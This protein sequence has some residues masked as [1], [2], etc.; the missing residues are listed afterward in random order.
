[1]PKWLWGEDGQE[2][3]EGRT[4]P[5][6][7]Q[8]LQTLGSMQQLLVDGCVLLAS[9]VMMSIVRTQMLQKAREPRGWQESGQSMPKPSQPSLMASCSILCTSSYESYVGR[10]SWLKHVC[11]VGSVLW[12]GAAIIW[13]EG[14]RA[15]KPPGGS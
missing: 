13:N 4:R 11:A 3:G 9:V 12:V 2:G 7:D 15:A 14:Q 5:V 1:M 6:G 8:I 10:H